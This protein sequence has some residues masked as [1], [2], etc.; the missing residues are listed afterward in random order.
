[1]ALWIETG[2]YSRPR[3]EIN[4]RIC[5]LCSESRI[6]R[7]LLPQIETEAHFLFPCVQHI[8]L[9]LKWFSMISKP[10]NFEI[11]NGVT[12]LDIV[13]NRAENCKPTAQFIVDAYGVRS[14]LIT[15]AY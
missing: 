2:R 13:L 3:L 10:E 6:Q 4:E 9:R 5:P 7:G 1:M 11:L 14:K 15:K 12:K 8:N